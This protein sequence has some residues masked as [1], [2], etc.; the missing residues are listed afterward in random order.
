[1]SFQAA[2]LC[3]TRYAS[4]AGLHSASPCPILYP[5]FRLPDATRIG[6]LKSFR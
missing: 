5:V 6:S 1:M 2:F 3:F 4:P